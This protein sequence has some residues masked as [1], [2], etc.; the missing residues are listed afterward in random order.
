MV[1]LLV[2]VGGA[3]GAMARHGFS[4]LIHQRNPSG[5]FPLA[6]LLINVLGSFAIGLLSGVIV[7]GRWHASLETRTFLI[8]GVLG[9]FT[10]FSSFS[11][12]TLALVREGHLGMALGNVVGQLVLSLVGVWLGFRLGRYV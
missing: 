3:L 8:V 12:D 1:W 4:R 9:G 10:T 11:F 6:I 7:S 2:G 5:T